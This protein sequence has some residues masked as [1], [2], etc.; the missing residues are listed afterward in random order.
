MNANEINI[1]SY[2]K[3]GLIS[4]Y[5]N[6]STAKWAATHCK[7]IQAILHGDDGTFWMTVPAIARQLEGMGYEIVAYAH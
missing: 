5:N 4:R 1:K 6:L 2:E 7:K 3:L